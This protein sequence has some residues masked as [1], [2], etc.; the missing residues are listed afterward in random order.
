[1]VSCWGSRQDKMFEVSEW[2]DVEIQLGSG[3]VSGVNWYPLAIVGTLEVNDVRRDVSGM[4][5]V[6]SFIES[7]VSCYFDTSSLRVIP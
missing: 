5:I 3:N 7:G 6:E 4:E 2:S 1:M